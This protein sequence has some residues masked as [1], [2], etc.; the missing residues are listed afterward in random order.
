MSDR[1]KVNY[2]DATYNPLAMRCTRKSKGCDRCWHLPM[3]R[4]LV[5]QCKAAGVACYVK[6]L[7]I[8]G[9][10]VHDMAAFPEDLRVRQ[11][12]KVVTL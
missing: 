9:K 12:P 7:D 2:L 5:E 3:A 8:G 4:S 11:F 1:T 6:Q 10:V